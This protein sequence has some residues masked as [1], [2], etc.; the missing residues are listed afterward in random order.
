MLSR[1]PHPNIIHYHG[2]QVQRRYIAGLVFNQHSNGLA[3][4]LKNMVGTINKEPL[5]QA[6]ESAIH[7]LHS[8]GW[9]HNDIN[10][11]NILVD[12]AGILVLNDLSSSREIGRK[13]STSRETKGWI[14]EDMK[15]YTTSE[16]RY[17]ISALAKI[18]V[19]LDIPTFDT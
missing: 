4:Y 18:R 13:L 12:E 5:M 14:D 19:W 15:D 1:H 9:A 8:L 10:P 11:S 3:Q 6:L 2:C 16:K 17:D 7:H